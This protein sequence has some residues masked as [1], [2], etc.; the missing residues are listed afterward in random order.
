MAKNQGALVEALAPLQAKL[1]A[2]DFLAAGALSLADIAYIAA[3]KP[4]FDKVCPARCTS[5][6]MWRS[7]HLQ[8]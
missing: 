7:P 2:S 8:R 4:A 5:P 3:L 6:M 1:A